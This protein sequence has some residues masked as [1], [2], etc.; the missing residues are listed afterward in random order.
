MYQNSWLKQTILW[1]VIQMK[2]LNVCNNCIF[3]TATC[4]NVIA[5]FCINTFWSDFLIHMQL[6]KIK[7]I[8]N[9]VKKTL[10]MQFQHILLYDN[11]MF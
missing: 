2:T 5:L 3:D 4:L 8:L 7:Y 10:F 1:A 9:K 6:Y 11:S